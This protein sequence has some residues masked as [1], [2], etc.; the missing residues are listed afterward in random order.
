V[1][2]HVKSRAIFGEI[3]MCLNEV[4]DRNNFKT[5]A[6]IDNCLTFLYNNDTPHVAC[7]RTN[8]CEVRSK[9]SAE[10]PNHVVLVCPTPHIRNCSGT[11]IGRGKPRDISA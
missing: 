7:T 6:K 8:K 5:A 9:A 4:H 2:L 3:K 11:V 10:D 1:S